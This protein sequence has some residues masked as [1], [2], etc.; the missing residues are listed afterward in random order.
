MCHQL[1]DCPAASLGAWA[2]R[3]VCGKCSREMPYS[4]TPCAH[5]GN[6]FTKPGGAHWQG[7]EGCRDQQRLSL[8][9]AQKFRGASV[10]GVKKTTSAKSQRVGVQGKR[11]TLAKKAAGGA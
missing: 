9:D 6:T 8:K 7:G 10:A 3:M 2:N 11:N 5:C 4:D 1:S